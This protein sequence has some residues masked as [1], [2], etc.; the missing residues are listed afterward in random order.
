MSTTPSAC[1]TSSDAEEL[2]T[3]SLLDVACRRGNRLL[4][5]G[6]TLE[7]RAGPRPGCADATAAARP[8]CCACSP[9]WRR[10]SRA[11]CC[12]AARRCAR[13][14][15][16]TRALVYIGHANALEG[17]PHGDRV[18]ALPGAPAR[19]RRRR[20]RR[21][22]DALQRLGMAA[23]RDALGAHAVAGPAPPRRAGAAGA[24]SASRRCG[25]STSRSTRSTPTASQALNDAA[26]T[27][28][29]RARRHRAAD[30]PP[31]ADARRAGADVRPRPARLTLRRSHEPPPSPPSSPA[32]CAWPRAGASRRCCRSSSSSSR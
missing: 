31:A 23:R 9:G 30:Q 13:R 16:F 19:S 32:T 12:G 3:L 11:V 2:P 4:F 28:H 17:R 7:L 29:A 10:P 25:C 24:A 26:R 18:A 20:R 22:G 8:A 15:G 1:A 14:R 21:C 5:K 6:V 27:Q